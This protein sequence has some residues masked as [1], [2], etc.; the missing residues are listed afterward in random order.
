MPMRMLPDHPLQTTL[1]V[2]LAKD[3]SVGVGAA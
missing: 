1:F 2:E 3:V